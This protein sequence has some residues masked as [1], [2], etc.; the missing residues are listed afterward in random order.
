MNYKTGRFAR[1]HLTRLL[2]STI[3]LLL[4]LTA[5][6]KAQQPA[7]APKQLKIDSVTL[8]QGALPGTNRPWVKLVATFRSAPRWSD[9]VAFSFTAL[10]GANNQYRVLTGV[11]RYANIK[12]G[13]SRAVMYLSPNT[14]ERFVI[15]PVAVKVR[16]FKNE[17]SDEAQ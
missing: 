8:E 16:A 13:A 6:L 17:E 4:L 3:S 7:E 2:S 10:L 11:V 1:P 14:V 9:G 5:D 15:F 12:G